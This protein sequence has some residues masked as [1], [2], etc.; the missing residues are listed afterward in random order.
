MTSLMQMDTSVTKGSLM[1]EFDS[2]WQVVG[3]KFWGQI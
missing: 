3:K 1:G 2:L